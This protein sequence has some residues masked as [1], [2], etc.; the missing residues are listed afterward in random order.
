MKNSKQELRQSQFVLMYGPGSIIESPNGSRLIPSLE[1][2]K[3]NCNESFFTK[4]EIKD[5]RMSN[6]L[7]SQ[8]EEY[9]THL[10]SIPSNKSISEEDE[11]VIYST[12]IFPSWHVCYKRN[13]PI[14]YKNIISEDYCEAYNTDKC[15]GCTK[16][17]NPNVRF[18]RACPDGHLDEVNWRLEVHGN[19]EECEDVK[20]YLWKVNGSSLSEIT[21]ECPICHKKTTMND[22]YGNK[23]RCSGRLPE[24]EELFDYNV[25]A[26]RPI[27]K[28]DCEEKTSVL[29]K[30]SSSLRL[31]ITKTL[32]KIPKF[33]EKIMESFTNSE[34]K[35]YIRA[36]STMDKL[37]SK[38]N[39]KKEV[40]TF[41]SND[42]YRKI[43]SYLKENSMEELL[44]EFLKV[45]ERKPDFT[46]AIDEEFDSLTSAEKESANFSKSKFFNY[47]LKAIDYTFPL[48]VCAID[49]LT[50]VTAQL[51]YQRKPHPKKNKEKGE[52]EEYEEYGYVSVGYV[53][54]RRN[55][56]N[57]KPKKW[58]PAFKGVGEG[59][60]ITSP[61]NPLTYIP[62]L[63]EI[64]K[65]W[66]MYAPSTPDER[67]EINKPLF[68]WWHTLSHA[69]I[70]SLS[71]SGGYSSAALHERV[72]VNTETG[73]GG[74]LI[75][76]TSPGEDS[77]MGGLIDIVFNKK[78]FNKVLTNAMNTLL[79]CSNDPLCSSIELEEGEKNGSACH[80]C[81]LISETSCEHQN[82]LL[83]RHFFIR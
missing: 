14:L 53:N 61:E 41:T 40:I 60:F 45:K 44:N 48:K 76:N 5:V 19:T 56:S 72:Y 79:V 57:T 49:K 62:E 33:D 18:V 74:I 47:K 67:P 66:K 2:L 34:L 15:E 10:L 26:S 23:R 71:L 7:N 32:L 70:K 24:N 65:K 16:D 25:S 46:N 55:L 8:D 43:D 21:I 13:P 4:H 20:Y 58:Y 31:P 68:I 11:P 12:V 17:S 54:K 38:E 39:F 50:T 69:L 75:Y 36:I 29:Q 1:G 83:D 9:E 28:W 73:K 30:Q 63:D 59:I 78:E 51:F 35:G 77:G 64:I 81:L 3:N 82:T 6:M 37:P 27:R 42:E 80:N 22:I 52:N